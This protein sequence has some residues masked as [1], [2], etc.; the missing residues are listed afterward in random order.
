LRLG[1]G[2]PLPAP[3]DAFFT[4]KRLDI[5]SQGHQVAPI[6]FF[7][8]HLQGSVVVRTINFTVQRSAFSVQRSTFTGAGRRSPFRGCLV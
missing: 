7:L 3:K 4:L 1:F 2:F 8:K 5:P 6:A